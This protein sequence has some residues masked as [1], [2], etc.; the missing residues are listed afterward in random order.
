VTNPAIS[1]REPP[2]LVEVKRQFAGGRWRRQQHIYG[3]KP[4]CNE[5]FTQRAA[6]IHGGVRADT[7]LP[8]RGSSPA[9]RSHEV[10][11]ART[12]VPYEC[13]QDDLA[14]W[15]PGH[16]PSPP[17]SE[18]TFPVR[19]DWRAMTDGRSIPGGPVLL[20]K[21]DAG[22][23]RQVEEHKGVLP[24]TCPSRSRRRT[25]LR[26]IIGVRPGNQSVIAAVPGVAGYRRR[27]RACRE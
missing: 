11:V 7:P 10:K 8:E 5:A 21:S 9:R 12:Q 18:P 23:A 3:K 1:G 20:L 14:P 24:P 27:Q 26:L 6:S 16:P 22:V 2:L 25:I 17:T 15:L 19:P 13:Y 4:A